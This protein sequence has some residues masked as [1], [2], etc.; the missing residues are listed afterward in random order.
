MKKYTD[1]YEVRIGSLAPPLF[2][3]L[4]IP[5]DA[6]R[7]VQAD[8]D[9]VVRLKVRGIIG[10]GASNTACRRLLRRMEMELPRL[11]KESNQKRTERAAKRLA[12]DAVADESAPT[13]KPS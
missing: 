12:N 7:H 13:D 2:K 8:A 10:E 3:Q 6:A 9:A 1:R 4:K 5:K 11:L